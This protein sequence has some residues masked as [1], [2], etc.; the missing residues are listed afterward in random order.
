MLNFHTELVQYQLQRTAFPED[1]LTTLQSVVFLFRFFLRLL[2]I[3][4]ASKY[5]TRHHNIILIYAE[6]ISYQLSQ[7][8]W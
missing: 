8:L 3:T 2:F 4:Y 6:N 5:D 7:F 1:H